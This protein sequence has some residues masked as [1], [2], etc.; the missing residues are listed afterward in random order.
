MNT[1]FFHVNDKHVSI[2]DWRGAGATY[3]MPEPFSRTQ[4]ENYLY[5]VRPTTN[6]P[7]FCWRGVMNQ[8]RGDMI[9]F[10]TKEC[11]EATALEKLDLVGMAPS[12][13]GL[14]AVVGNTIPNLDAMDYNDL[15]E[16]R[17]NLERHFQ[18]F[19]TI[20]CYADHKAQ[21]IELRLRGKIQS[22]EGEER[23][24]QALYEGIPEEYRW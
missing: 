1:I 4:I 8:G 22:A 20:T 21:A 2:L 14:P 13:M 17:S 3:H 15:Q 18:H 6:G 10:T 24:C 19:A 9:N 5:Q 11:R 23:L 12:E 7:V 16:F